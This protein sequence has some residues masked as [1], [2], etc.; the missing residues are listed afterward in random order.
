MMFYNAGKSEQ[1]AEMHFR[2]QDVSVFYVVRQKK[3]IVHSAL[4]IASMALKRFPLKRNPPIKEIS[5][6]EN[7]FYL[8]P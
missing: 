3:S 4:S 1:A 8:F 6:Q 7:K 2:E 5:G